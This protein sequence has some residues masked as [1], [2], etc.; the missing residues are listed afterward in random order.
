MT[1]LWHRPLAAAIE[2]LGPADVEEEAS[3]R[4]GGGKTLET[5]ME[6][7]ERSRRVRREMMDMMK[8]PHQVG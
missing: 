3:P 7:P 6:H 8:N 2:R 1:L 5:T 4:G